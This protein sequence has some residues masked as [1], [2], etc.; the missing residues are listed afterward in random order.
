MQLGSDEHKELFCRFFIDTHKPF[1]PEEL[2]WPDL[3]Q[4]V[5]D[6]LKNFPPIQMKNETFF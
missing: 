5:I 2:N 3:S 1:R 4:S 6:K